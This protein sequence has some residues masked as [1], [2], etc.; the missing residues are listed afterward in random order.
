MNRVQSIFDSQSVFPDFS[1]EPNVEQAVYSA[2]EGGSPSAMFAPLHYEPNYAYPLLVWLHGP[3]DNESQLRRIMP[4]LSMR[5]Y[6][7]VAP[8]GLSPVGREKGRATKAT[9]DTSTDHL[10]A[11]AACV[12]DS[13]ERACSRFNVA[14]NRIFLAG[15]DRGGTMAFRLAMAYPGRF[16]GVLSL[17]GCLPVGGGLLSRLSEV[18]SLPV[19]MASGK[20]SEACPPGRVCSD[21]RL[22]HS[23]GM[24]IT[25]RQYPCGQE[26]APQMLSDMDRW[27][28][29]LVTQGAVGSNHETQ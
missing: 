6:V 22:F 21:L 29:D 19:F 20:N 12:F 26:L 18:R 28:M 3:A 24:D 2:V 7:A 17:G 9:W 4:T 15:F 8:R 10:P 16:A 13:I 11:T 1:L 23:A 5:N 14:A 27:M 25:L